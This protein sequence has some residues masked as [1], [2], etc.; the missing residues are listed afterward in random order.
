MDPIREDD[1]HAWVDDQLSPEQRQ[2]VERWLERNP[3]EAARFV[4]YRAH[5][6]QL[7]EAFA[8]KLHEPVT[9]SLCPEI[10]LAVRRRAWQRRFRNV[11]ACVALLLAG[12]VGGWVVR[13]QVPT[14][15][16]R[17]A[18]DAVQAHLTFVTE[19]RH[20][21]E[22]PAG[23]EAHLVTWLSNRLG[24]PLRVP[25][26]SGFGFHLVGGRLLP[27]EAVPAAQFM[28]EDDGGTRLTLYLRQE[29]GTDTGFELVLKDGVAGF[30]WFERGF[31]YV[32][33]AAI[34]RERLLQMAESIYRQLPA[35]WPKTAS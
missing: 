1:L 18:A 27:S 23:Q 24:Q 16:A 22:V 13:G 15:Q 28:F 26:L 32:V 11:A 31:G 19:V 35:A 25:D 8:P 3:D 5:R 34:S 30:R 20:P 6:A 10:L 33:L 9:V 21:V 4:A 14:T 29:A 7:R 2:F 12:G 17:L